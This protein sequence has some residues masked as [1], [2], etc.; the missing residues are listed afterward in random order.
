MIII[1]YYKRSCYGKDL[2]YLKNTHG[3]QENSILALI[4]QRTITENQMRLFNAL[5]IS[6][7]QVLN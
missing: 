2:Y 6:F 5:G 1:E 7:K 4:G 3:I